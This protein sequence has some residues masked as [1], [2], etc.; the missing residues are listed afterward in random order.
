MTN[1]K[2]SP[3]RKLRRAE[4]PSESPV[5]PDDGMGRRRRRFGGKSGSSAGL[6]ERTSHEPGGSGGLTVVAFIISQ[7]K[8][9]APYSDQP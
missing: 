9:Q 1:A 7:W 6:G 5:A 8:V 3:G 2:A 4:A